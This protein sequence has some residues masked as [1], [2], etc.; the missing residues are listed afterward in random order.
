[1]INKQNIFC[2]FSLGLAMFSMFFGSGNTVFPVL[3]GKLAGEQSLWAIVGLLVT[4]VFLP[5]VGLITMFLFKGNYFSFFS[6]LGKVPA[7]IVVSIIFSLIG[8]F[9]VIPRCIVISYSSLNTFYPGWISLSWFSFFS[10]IIIYSF[11]IKRSNIINILG[12]VLT[13]VLLFSLILIITKGFF[14]EPIVL[15]TSV[16]SKTTAFFV[17]LGE[18]YNTMDI[19]GSF[20]F[21]GVVLKSI[22]DLDVSSF[23]IRLKIS[24]IS[25]LI[26][27]AL[28]GYVYVGMCVVASKY[29]TLLE[30][31]PA[32]E[33][34]STIALNVLG[35]RF[36]F[37]VSVAV[38]LACLTTAISLSLVFSEFLNER[39]SNNKL[40]YRY[41]LVI[42]LVI[43][44]FFSSLDFSGIQ[45]FIVPIL[46]LM[47]PAL[48]VLTVCNLLHKL[49]GFELVKIPF[50]L[51]LCCSAC[52]YLFY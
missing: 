7:W 48:V 44:G 38:A 11:T 52:Y 2:I 13:P 35:E 8:P 37:I 39:V 49:Y 32:Q 6:R 15:N 26:A 24:L 47:M 17:G 16:M 25:S 20:V 42:T 30:Q 5:F 50:Y 41:S 31:V 1:M 3:V 4:A 9:A 33:L 10:V 18:G 14:Y 22:V 45:S 29:S 46:Q 12:N 43:A 36:G 21:S 19:L 40:S 34:L 27:M 23:S 28:L 51:T